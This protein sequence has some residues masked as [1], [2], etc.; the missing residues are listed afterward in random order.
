M[1]K[2][3]QETDSVVGCADPTFS[4][5]MNFLVHDPNT[6]VLSATVYD[7]RGGKKTV[8]G[9]VKIRLS[10]LIFKS[11]LTMISNQF[12]LVDQDSKKSTAAV[13]CAQISLSMA[14]RY[15][16][17]PAIAGHGAH[18]DLQDLKKIIPRL[19]FIEAKMTGADFMAT[20]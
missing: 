11:S 20:G 5:R 4:H 6:D 7:H 13:T 1:C 19:V 14:L 3:T 2:V 18:R 16:H 10:G 15:I 8:I 9:T 17:R 12:P